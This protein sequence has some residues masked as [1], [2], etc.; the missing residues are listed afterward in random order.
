ML[1]AK[2]NMSQ[3]P[4]VSIDLPVAR[5]FSGKLT[6]DADDEVLGAEIAQLI[7]QELKKNSA[8]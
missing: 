6:S 7:F 8:P 2:E 5:A 4:I 1:V 3:Q